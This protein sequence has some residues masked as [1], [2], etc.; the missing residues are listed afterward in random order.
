MIVARGS[1]ICLL[2]AKR[3]LAA[4]QP[5]IAAPGVRAP[6]RSRLRHEVFVGEHVHELFTTCA[7]EVRRWKP[8][9]ARPQMKF[10]TTLCCCDGST[11]QYEVVRGHGSSRTSR[12]SGA[13]RAEEERDAQPLGS[14]RSPSSPYAAS[15][16]SMTIR[17]PAPPASHRDDRRR[18]SRMADGISM[19]AWGRAR[20]PVQVPR[21]GA[22]LDARGPAEASHTCIS[23][24]SSSPVP[25]PTLTS[26]Q[27]TAPTVVRLLSRPTLPAPASLRPWPSYTLRLPARPNKKEKKKG[28]HEHLAGPC[29]SHW[30]FPD[31]ASTPGTWS[32]GGA[33]TAAE[34][35]SYLVV[36]GPSN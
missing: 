31:C 36:R 2:Q 22:L 5:P 24:T 27:S 35:C 26:S 29:P 9:W 32:L 17:T 4:D 21:G 23:F 25:A 3:A 6:P 34:P 11:R 19:V 10:S 28:E 8:S 33:A 30:C 7:L 12:A 20:R 1:A 16:L 18:R 13:H 15:L 14:G